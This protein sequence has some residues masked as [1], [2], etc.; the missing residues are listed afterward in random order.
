MTRTAYVTVTLDDPPTS[1]VN[2]VG[3][4]PTGNDKNYTQSFSAVST[5]TVNHN[6]GKKPSTFVI[7]SAGDELDAPINHVSNDQLVVNFSASTSGVIHCN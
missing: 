2:I 3:V 5:V 7:D 4:S 1:A 6:L